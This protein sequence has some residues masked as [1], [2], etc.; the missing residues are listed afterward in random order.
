MRRKYSFNRSIELDD[1]T[2]CPFARWSHNQKCHCS[3]HPAA[4]DPFHTT[5]MA[6]C[7]GNMQARP[8]HCP[9][10]NSDK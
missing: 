7:F 9:M 6:E 8:G 10:D 1:A 2:E 5:T 4:Y 3:L